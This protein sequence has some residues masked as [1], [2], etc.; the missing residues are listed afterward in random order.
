[1]VAS[2]WEA[3]GQSRAGTRQGDS[4]YNAHANRADEGEDG[5]DRGL[6]SARRRP[7]HRQTLAGGV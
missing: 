7:G 1:M 3:S 2:F 6:V 4:H 5:E